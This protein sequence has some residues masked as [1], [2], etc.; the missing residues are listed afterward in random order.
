MIPNGVDLKCAGNIPQKFSAILT[1]WHHTVAVELSAAH[2]FLP[3]Q[4]TTDVLFLFAVWW[5]GR[6]FEYTDLI[7]CSSIQFAI[8][9]PLLYDMVAYWKQPSEDWYI[10]GIKG[11]KLSATVLRKA[12]EFK[13]CFILRGPIWPRK[14]SPHCCFTASVLSFWQHKSMPNSDPTIRM[15]QQKLGLIKPGKISNVFCSTVLVSWILAT[16]FCS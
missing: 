9:W 10:V 12:V 6:P 3:F 2:A 7:S 16:V 5:I 15:S 1:W 4:Y 13:C 14:L 8:T 11:I